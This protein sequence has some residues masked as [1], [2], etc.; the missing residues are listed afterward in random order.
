MIRYDNLIPPIKLGH[1]Q[2]V[3]NFGYIHHR[4]FNSKE[5]RLKRTIQH[6]ENEIELILS[7]NIYC[8][9]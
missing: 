9:Q 8:L 5:K 2:Y 4:R 1:H 7:S 3:T 6:T